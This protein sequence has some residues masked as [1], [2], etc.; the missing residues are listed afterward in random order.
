M[1]A[2]MRMSMAWRAAKV[3]MRTFFFAG[4]AGRGRGG[5]QGAFLGE[6]EALAERVEGPGRPAGVVEAVVGWRGGYRR[7]TA[8]LGE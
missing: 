6:Q 5:T 4:H 2:G 8:R 1:R 7:R 3:T